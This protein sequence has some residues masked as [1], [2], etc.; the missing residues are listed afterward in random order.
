MRRIVGVLLGVVMLVGCTG[1]PYPTTAMST[2]SVPRLEMPITLR[3]G[4]ADP[5]G[6]RVEV[7]AGTTIV[8]TIT[9]DRDDEVHVHGYD[10]EI[11][12]KAGETITKEV[13]LDQV[14]RFEVESHEP[15]LTILQLVVS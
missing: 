6:Q 3:D 10:V 8:F 15:A 12:V 5:N 2:S 4:K 13:L 11:P 14:G 1:T 9:S 7:K